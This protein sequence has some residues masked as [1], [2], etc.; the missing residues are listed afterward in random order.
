M[1]K[2]RITDVDG[3]KCIKLSGLITGNLSAYRICAREGE[4]K[5]SLAEICFYLFC[6]FV[7]AKLLQSCPTLCDPMKSSLP[8]SS[9]QGILQARIL[10]WVAIICNILI[11]EGR[12]VMQTITESQAQ[13]QP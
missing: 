5:V 11:V 12:T 3:R 9:I 10:E 7:S 8:G 13:L 4:E 1:E 2:C 6:L